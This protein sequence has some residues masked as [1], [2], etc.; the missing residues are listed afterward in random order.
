M[1]RA[2]NE[3]IIEPEHRLPAF[4][5]LA[6]PKQWLKNILVVAAPGAAGVLTE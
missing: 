6:R 2:R 4:L 5:R 3:D 1:R